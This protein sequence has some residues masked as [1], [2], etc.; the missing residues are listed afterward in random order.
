[1]P[2]SV[3]TDANN[4]VIEVLVSARKAAGLRQ[5][6]LAVKLGKDQSF[7]SRIESGQRRVDV[8]EFYAIA[9]ALRADPAKLYRELVAKLPATVEI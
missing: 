7:V 8:I 1:M 3:F 2:K 9:M 4:A 5:E 6:D